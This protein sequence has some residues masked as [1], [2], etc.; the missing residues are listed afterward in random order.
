MSRSYRKPY[1]AITGTSSAKDD[2]RLAARGMRRKQNLW[3]RTT[4]VEELEDSGLVP[5][6][7]ECAWNEVY[8]WGRD[9]HQFIWEPSDWEWYEYHRTQI[10]EFRNDWDR[11]YSLRR[12][13][14]WPPIWYEKL[15]RK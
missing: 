1:T 9:G 7:F 3:L 6:R 11:N 12:H 14:H 8:C 13:N 10:G 15:K 5:H 4:S 2:K